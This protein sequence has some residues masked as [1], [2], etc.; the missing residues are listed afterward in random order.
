M[1]FVSEKIR[2]SWQKL[3]EFAHKKLYDL[4]G[5]EYVKTDGYKK[6]NTFP[7]SGWEPFLPE[8]RM[9]GRDAHF[10]LRASFKTP[11]KKEN[12]SYNIRCTTGF[13]GQWD[14]TNP[15]G[16]IYLNGDMVQGVDTNHTEIYLEPD[17]EYTMYNYF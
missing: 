4:E 2:I 9:N 16:L 3:N 12:T 11:P 13:E 5:V 17:T 8:T 10:W 1:A 6:D 15:Q 14:G 7:E